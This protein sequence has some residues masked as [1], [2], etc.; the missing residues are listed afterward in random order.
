MQEEKK[1][2]I[3]Q[4]KTV[5]ISEFKKLLNN[6]TL[7]KKGEEENL[8][9]I[10]LEPSFKDADNIYLEKIK[11][12]RI[13]EG[14]SGEAKQLVKKLLEKLNNE[15]DCLIKEYNSKGKEYEFIVCG[16]EI[17]KEKMNCTIRNYEFEKEIEK[18]KKEREIFEIKYKK[19]EIK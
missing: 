17:A 2:I 13:V 11:E 18:L 7:R 6:G 12:N 16:L 3:I 9:A 1:G 19:K 10:C 14:L 15:L 5:T 8:N 4:T